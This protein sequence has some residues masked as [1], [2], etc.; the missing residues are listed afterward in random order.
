MAYNT[1]YFKNPYTGQLREAPVGYSWSC[2]FFG[3]A[4]AF[5]RNDWKWLFTMAISSVISGGF[6]WLFIYPFIYNGLYIQDLINNGYKVVSIQIGA[7][8]VLERKIGLKLE[9]I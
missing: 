7:I 1:I 5:Y 3:F 9:S 2:L 6:L 4:V 8:N